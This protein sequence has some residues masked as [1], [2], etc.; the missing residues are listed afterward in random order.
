M[1]RKT[2]VTRASTG[3]NCTLPTPRRRLRTAKQVSVIKA[4]A[5]RSAGDGTQGRSSGL[6]ALTVF[7]RLPAKHV[8]FLT[9]EDGAEPHL[10]KGEFAVV[11]TTDR[12]PQHGELYVIQY[13]GS[14]RRRALVQVRSDRLN[15]T[16]PGAEPSLVWWCGDLRGWRQTDEKT[17]GCP[18]FAGMSDGPYRTENLQPKLI[19]RVVGVAFTAL[20]NQLPTCAGW[21][22][23]EA[24]NAAFDPAEYLDILIRT[25][26]EPR[27]QGDYYFEKMP[28]R[29]LTKAE[30]AAVTA[31]RWKYVKASTALIRLKAE[32]V[33]RGLDDGRR[34]A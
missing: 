15:I 16:G 32:C 18:V 22:D 34:A 29:A 12:D 5:L 4:A 31:V 30:Q 14:E 20:G 26:H 23:E 11:D 7:D 13:Q 21:E 25:G 1:R 6:R 17:L 9:S 24:G 27:I 2:K 19:G 8:T 28:D 3:T 33:R 10:C